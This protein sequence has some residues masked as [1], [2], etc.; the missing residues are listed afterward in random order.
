MSLAILVTFFPP[1]ET[2]RAFPDADHDLLPSN[3]R[4]PPKARTPGA[5]ALPAAGHR[6][7]HPGPELP[8]RPRPP[9]APSRGFFI[10]SRVAADDPR[11]S[12]P[13]RGSPHLHVR[14]RPVGPAGGGGGSPGQPAPRGARPAPRRPSIP[15]VSLP[16]PS[17]PVPV[18]AAGRRRCPLAAAPA[19]PA[20]GAGPPPRRTGAF[21]NR[22]RLPVATRPM[23]G[24]LRP[25]RK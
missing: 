13:P 6:T 9:P 24:K 1:F 18:P 23:A 4:S 17:A 16:H 15:P 20:A 8:P 21:S 10:P 2:R 25:K 19:F 5:G 11:P 3:H 7:A 12:P 22:R 14:H